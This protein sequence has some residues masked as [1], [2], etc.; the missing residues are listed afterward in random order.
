MLAIALIPSA[1]LL[2]T[3]VASTSVLVRD[4]AD[5]REWADWL[6]SQTDPILQLMT[7][8]Q[9]ERTASL[10][11]IAGD[12]TALSGISTQRKATDTALNVIGASTATYKRI[13]PAVTEKVLPAYIDFVSHLPTIRQ[14]VDIQHTTADEIFDFYSKGASL[15][16]DNLTLAARA[17]PDNGAAMEEMS[18]AGL[19][20]AA[21]MH[22]RAV[23]LIS[24]ALEDG[25]LDE[26]A[27]L[28]LAQLVGACRYGLD[29]LSRRVPPSV[30]DRYRSLTTGPE[31]RTAVS[32]EDGLS[33]PGGRT[34]S[35]DE[36]LS[37][38]NSIDSQLMAL[39]STQYRY[40]ENVATDAANRLLE[41]SALAGAATVA[42]AAAA[43]LAGI[44]LANR[45]V[46]R[47]QALRTKTLTLAHKQ[48][49]SIIQRMQR[50]ETV[51]VEVEMPVVDHSSDEIGQVAQAFNSAQRTAVDAAD[52]E[53]KTRRGVNRVF[54]DIAYRSQI[55]IHRQLSL[56]DRAE[57]KQ[58]DPEHL[59]LLFEL[60]HLTTRARRNAENLVILSGGKI[61][62]KW[63]DPVQLEDMV[64][65]AISET[66]DFTR[67]SA[68][69]IPVIRILGSA[70]ADVIHLLAELV[71]NA[72][73]FS[74]PQ[75]PVSVHGNLVGKG[76]VVEID[77]QG[78]GIGFE[79]RALL[80]EALRNPPDFQEM[81]LAG[82]RNLGIFV[83]G[84][85]AQKHG[86]TVSLAESPYG[87]TKAIVLIPSSLLDSKVGSS[88][89]FAS[90]QRAMTEV[91]Y[92]P[93]R[94][95][96]PAVNSDFTGLSP[97]WTAS[98]ESEPISEVIV[99]AFAPQHVSSPVIE[100]T[101]KRRDRAALPRRERQ[102]QLA[103][104]L[105]FEGATPENT[106]PSRK[107]RNPD[108]AHNA[109]ASFQRGTKHAR[110]ARE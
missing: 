23:G 28:K 92:E 68:V 32:V 99:P 61:G 48:L 22:S 89:D 107:M 26:A 81:A 105:Q 96:V 82:H 4:S 94:D 65:S 40:A 95:P 11:A 45:L 78:L 66:Q 93:A 16:I 83:I 52:A 44:M 17:T 90:D 108:E 86:I 20:E 76:V 12:N 2:I 7:S 35:L 71:D 51:D 64:R 84:Q 6:G 50:G 13:N 101:P 55:I 67:V 33:Q 100:P 54:T 70:V 21:E 18:A 14:S 62:R 15:V 36:W 60:D 37:V 77:D 69:R 5:A 31:W 41:R 46:R 102:A 106:Q 39:W 42:L 98:I 9:N 8:L 73:S 19:L 59:E 97:I 109:M 30:L 85:L 38:E 74:P 24:H 103:P 3:G 56:L 27:R 110:G 43:I 29:G 75:A 91:A 57:G 1:A 79:D 10:R 104:Q 53:S 34:V 49:P 87:G 63:R 88:P 80:N 47:L 58:N 25:P 72:T